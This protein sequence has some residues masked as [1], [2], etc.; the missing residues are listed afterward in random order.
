MA[1]TENF[2]ASSRYNWS[3]SYAMEVIELP[4]T[5]QVMAWRELQDDNVW[6]QGWF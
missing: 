5:V 2:Y 6:R 4:E 1:G 3:S